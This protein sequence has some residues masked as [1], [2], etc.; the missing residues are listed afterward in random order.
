MTHSPK[1]DS[2]YHQVWQRCCHLLLSPPFVFL[3]TLLVAT[4]YLVAFPAN[5]N[6]VTDPAGSQGACESR[7]IK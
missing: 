7:H 1:V 4:M 2:L 6:A 5:A 3:K